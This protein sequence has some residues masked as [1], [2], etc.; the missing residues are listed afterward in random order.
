[1]PGRSSPASKASLPDGNPRASARET[2][3]AGQADRRAVN[4]RQPS[5]PGLHA[6]RVCHAAQRAGGDGDLVGKRHP[7]TERR[8]LAPAGRGQASPRKRS[9]RR[10]GAGTMS[11]GDSIIAATVLLH[12]LPLVTRNEAEKPPVAADRDRC[13]LCPSEARDRIHHPNLARGRSVHRSHHAPGCGQQR[14]FAGGS[15][16]GA[17]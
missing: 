15:A 12:R 7:Q 17:R 9:M 6:N 10:N 5:W 11:V 1:M 2:A 14:G 13:L 16:Q 4:P 8:S 3:A